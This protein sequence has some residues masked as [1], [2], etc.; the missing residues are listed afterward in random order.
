[1]KS[2]TGGLSIEM[3]LRVE[4]GVI[5]LQG[6]VVLNDVETPF[7]GW[8][9]LTAILEQVR[10]GGSSSPSEPLTRTELKVASLVAEGLTNPQIASRLSVSPRTV[11]G[12]LYRI[13]KK[14]GARTRTQL[15][16]QIADRGGG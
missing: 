1:M 7:S 15:A 6:S 4:R 2:R 12:H 14:V 3:I 13:F 11:Q 8:L 16:R 10:A 9:E 5:P